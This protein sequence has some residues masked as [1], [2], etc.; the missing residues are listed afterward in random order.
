M[1]V[2]FPTP[3]FLVANCQLTVAP[4][5]LGAWAGVAPPQPFPPRCRVPAQ[6]WWPCLEPSAVSPGTSQG[7]PEGFGKPSV[8]PVTPRSSAVNLHCIDRGFSEVPEVLEQEWTS[9]SPSR[10]HRVPAHPHRAPTFQSC[11]TS[12]SHSVTSAPSPVPRGP[13]LPSTSRGCSCPIPVP[14]HRRSS[15]AAQFSLSTF[16]CR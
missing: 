10:Q 1:E 12:T 5:L 6:G 8:L 7:Q 9:L 3:Y 11:A 16:H 15:Q 2:P 13:A 14:R 4:S